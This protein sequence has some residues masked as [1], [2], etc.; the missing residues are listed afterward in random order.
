M[1]LTCSKHADAAVDDHDNF[2]NGIPDPEIYNL[3]KRSVQLTQNDA[4]AAGQFHLLYKQQQHQQSKTAP[5]I[6]PEQQPQQQFPTRLVV[7][8]HPVRPSEEGESGT[9]IYA[10][11]W[12]NTSPTSSAAGRLQQ[13]EQCPRSL[14]SNK[15]SAAV[16][17]IIDATPTSMRNTATTATTATTTIT[18]SLNATE[19]AIASSS[20]I[21]GILGTSGPHQLEDRQR[22][23]KA[24]S[25]AAGVLHAAADVCITDVQQ[26]TDHLFATATMSAPPK[27][28]GACVRAC[29]RVLLFEYY[30]GSGMGSDEYA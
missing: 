11:R 5:S 25:N 22:V 7:R 19:V 27:R 13:Q 12:T 10:L 8:R 30:E 15:K 3:L 20:P 17:D 1:G 29:A 21:P 28:K 2:N 4:A 6:H 16:V 18:T 23:A 9:H 14:I 26:S 24:V